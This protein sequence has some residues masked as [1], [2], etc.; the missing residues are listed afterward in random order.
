MWPFKKKEK[1]SEPGAQ[2]A[3]GGDEEGGEKASLIPEDASIAQKINLIGV[4]LTKINATLESF[5]ETRKS[6]TERFSLINEQV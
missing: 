5:K 3:A 6:T 2:P 4:E 1:S